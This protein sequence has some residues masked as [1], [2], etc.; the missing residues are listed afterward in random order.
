[1]TM[2]NPLDRELEMLKPAID[3]K[4]MYR[5]TWPGQPPK[6]V[7]GDELANLLKGADHSMLD[8]QEAGD[9]PPAAI[10]GDRETTP[11]PHATA[12]GRIR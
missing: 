9:A 2:R 11:D 5:Y 7:A 8:I 12:R 1:M 3:P 10:D 4:K 6:V